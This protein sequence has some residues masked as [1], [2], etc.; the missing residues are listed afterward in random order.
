MKVKDYLS[1][2][3]PLS[4]LDEL[5]QVGPAHLRGSRANTARVLW[6]L[7]QFIKSRKKS[8]P[9]ETAV[10]AASSN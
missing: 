6:A 10:E 9:R 7:E 4:T 2:R 1:L 3:L 5:E 8:V